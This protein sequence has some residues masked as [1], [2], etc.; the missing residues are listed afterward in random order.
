MSK[1]DD[2]PDPDSDAWDMENEVDESADASPV[3]SPLVATLPGY[4]LFSRGHDR[5]FF[6]FFTTGVIRM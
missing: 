3:S 1:V 2:Q 4:C 5:Y 6:F